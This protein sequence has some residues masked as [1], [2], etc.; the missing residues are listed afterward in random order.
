M[1]VQQ[2]SFSSMLTRRGVPLWR[3]VEVLQWAAQIISAVVVIAFLIFF[4]SNVLRAAEIRGLSLG[5]DFVNLTAGF[6]LPEMMIEYTPADSF[7]RAFVVGLLNTIKVALVGI[8]LATILGTLVALARLSS[9]WL[10]S[11]IASVYIEIIR[12]IP[13]LVQLFFWYFAVYQ[14]LPP[15]RDSIQWPGPVYLSQRGLY[16]KAPVATETFVPW[17]AFLLVGLLLAFVLRRVLFRYQMRTGKD[18]HYGLVA[19]LVMVSVPLAGWFL[20]SDVPIL[21]E[22]PVMGKFNF[23]GGLRLTPE[24]SALLTGLVIYTGSF[25]AEVVRAGIQAVSK[26]Q[27]EAA[28]ALGLSGGQVLRLV[29]MPQALRV[30]IPPLI[31]QYL[32]LT[33]NSSL[34]IAIGYADVFFVGRTIIN[35][36]G[37][38][39]PVFLMVMAFYLF[40]SLTTS[41]LMN[42]YNRRI[43]LV[44]R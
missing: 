3:D 28:R 16:M 15:V 41:V 12:N 23:E 43:Q 27:F 20:V 34:A 18:T 5:Y 14:Q 42:I 29:V 13:L 30:I 33:K 11:R 38:A 8:V 7:G 19:A 6:D 22:D 26:G 4:V 1:S 40:T 25:I 35:Q 10:V 31:S 36:A 9:N 37:R 2:R 21:T 24:F 17:L 32:N 44:E 39:V